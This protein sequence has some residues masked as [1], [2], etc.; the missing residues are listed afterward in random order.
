METTVE[1]NLKSFDAKALDCDL[2]LQLETPGDGFGNRTIARWEGRNWQEYG[3][4]PHRSRVVIAYQDRLHVSFNKHAESGSFLESYLVDVRERVPLI[5]RPFELVGAG[6]VNNRLCDVSE[7]QGKV[8]MF[9]SLTNKIMGSDLFRNVYHED[10]VFTGTR[11]FYGISDSWLLKRFGKEG[12][13]IHAPEGRQFGAACINGGHLFSTMYVSSDE[14]KARFKNSVPVMSV[15]LAH[16]LPQFNDLT[17]LQVEGEDDGL[18]NADRLRTINGGRSFYFT[19][20]GEP[21][22]L[23]RQDIGKPRVA[24]LAV[25][26]PKHIANIT[27]FPHGMLKD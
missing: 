20:Y 22:T 11:G 12:E 23:Y 3:E 26:E 16:S 24:V 8:V 21:R 13:I 15:D 19:T 27:L 5:T 25:S 9:E 10:R 14:E 1:K 2:V 7:Y 17:A 6:V 4:F 18:H